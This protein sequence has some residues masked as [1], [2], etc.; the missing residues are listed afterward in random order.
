[1]EEQAKVAVDVLAVTTIQELEARIAASQ[2][3]GV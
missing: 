2:S 3:E 1:M